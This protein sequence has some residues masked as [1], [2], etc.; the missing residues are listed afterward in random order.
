MKITLEQLKKL[1]KDVI[2]ENASVNKKG[3]RQNLKEATYW[4]DDDEKTYDYD[5]YGESIYP[6][7]EEPQ[8]GMNAKKPYSVH[9][10]G[11][12]GAFNLHN[13]A[14]KT[15]NIFNN[16]DG[17]KYIYPDNVILVLRKIF[18]YMGHGKANKFLT[19]INNPKG[20]S[21]LTNYM[22]YHLYYTY[23]S[24]EI[25][26]PEQVEPSVTYIENIPYGM[27]FFAGFDRSMRVFTIHTKKIN[28]SKKKMLVKEAEKKINFNEFC[29]WLG[30][31]PE[32]VRLAI[33]I[34]E[35]SDADGA[36]TH[37]QDMGEEEAAEA[38][39]SIY[40]GDGYGSLKNAK[41]AFREENM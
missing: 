2:K 12:K 36:Y 6:D 3:S 24:N 22:A 19:T 11:K 5:N 25:L 28:E 13:L 40:F 32:A 41:A 38:V 39:Y 9:N 14:V 7:D 29:E 31:S 1:V 33:E 8:F 37:L 30:Y 34:T 27:D 17:K 10:A 16:I 26:S 35:M 21:M 20:I 15:A 18:A 4:G 23:D